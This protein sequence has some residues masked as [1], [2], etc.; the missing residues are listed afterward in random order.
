[1]KVRVNNDDSLTAFV[2]SDRG[3][4]AITAS[5]C[6]LFGEGAIF[7]L[8]DAS[9]SVDRTFLFSTNDDREHREANLS[10]KKVIYFQ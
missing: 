7:D 9:I 4:Q 2:E 1:M 3:I 6:Q 8:P 10:I 5:P